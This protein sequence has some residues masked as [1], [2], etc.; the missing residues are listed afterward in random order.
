MHR[1]CSPNCTR[2]AGSVRTC[3]GRGICAG[4]RVQ[5]QALQPSLVPWQLLSCP[6][7]LC[8]LASACRPYMQV[9]PV[10]HDA[11]RAPDAVCV[12]RTLIMEPHGRPALQTSGSA[13]GVCPVARARRFAASWTRTRTHAGCRSRDTDGYANAVLPLL[14]PV[15]CHPNVI[16]LPVEHGHCM[17]ALD[18]YMCVRRMFPCISAPGRA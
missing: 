15:G 7:A 6:S 5:L 13:V 3:S 17:Q 11:L 2:R 8:T 10:L 1:A 18:S 12:A 4:A 16:Q 9:N 14:R